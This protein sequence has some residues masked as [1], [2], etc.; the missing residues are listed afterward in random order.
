MQPPVGAIS[1]KVSVRAPAVAAIGI[2]SEADIARHLPEHAIAQ[3]VKAICAPPA[4]TSH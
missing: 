4:I 1:D 3:F 2:V